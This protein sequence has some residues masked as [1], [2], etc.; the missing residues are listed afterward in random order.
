MILNIYFVFF[1]DKNQCNTNMSMAVERPTK[2]EAKRLASQITVKQFTESRGS[3]PNEALRKTV[4]PEP[5]EPEDD[6]QH[7]QIE[8][9]DETEV[10]AM[11]A[12]V[13][14][15]KLAVK[16]PLPLVRGFNFPISDED[17]VELLEATVQVNAQVREEYVSIPLSKRSVEF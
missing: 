10:L 6:S 3:Y 16:R 1:L 12:A 11:A 2:D 14:T 13:H 9:I 4:K 17:T 5:V 15:Q 8:F 7:L